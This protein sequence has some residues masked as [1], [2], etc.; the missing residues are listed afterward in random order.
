MVVIHCQDRAGGQQLASRDAVPAEVVQEDHLV[1][2]GVSGVPGQVI[3]GE[4]VLIQK[5]RGAGEGT[6]CRAPM[7][8]T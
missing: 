1:G 8:V 4:K 6:T 3:E 7:A 5:A 2:E